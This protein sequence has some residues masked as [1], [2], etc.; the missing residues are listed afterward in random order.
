MGLVDAQFHKREAES[1]RAQYLPT[2]SPGRASSGT[3][4]ISLSEPT[5]GIWRAFP[6][7]C[8]LDGGLD[9]GL[10]HHLSMVSGHC[11][12]QRRPPRPLGLHVG[13]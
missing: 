6:P 9:L 8:V 3:P 2:G 13:K 11:G 1:E 12:S 7:F 4:C 10:L 5:V